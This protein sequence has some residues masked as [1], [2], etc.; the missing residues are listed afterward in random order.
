MYGFN[1]ENKRAWAE[2]YANSSW[3]NENNGMQAKPIHI[4]FAFFKSVAHLALL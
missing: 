1:D 2:K 3:D 4:F